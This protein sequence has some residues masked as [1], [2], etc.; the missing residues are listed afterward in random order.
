MKR[1][2][3]FCMTSVI[4]LACS[5]FVS[6]ACEKAPA[7]DPEPEQPAEPEPI[8]LT[9]PENGTSIDLI[10]AEDVVFSWENAKDVNSCKIR[11]SRSEDLSKLLRTPYADYPRRKLQA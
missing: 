8:V 3:R 11:F 7:A 9:A 10:N 4:A 2:L 5:M 6:V 1:N